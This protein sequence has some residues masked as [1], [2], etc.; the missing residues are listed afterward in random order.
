MRKQEITVGIDNKSD[1]VI[2]ADRSPIVILSCQK[3]EI[4]A[5]A[6]L[7]NTSDYHFRIDTNLKEWSLI[8]NVAEKDKIPVTV[9]VDFINGIWEYY[10]EDYVGNPIEYSLN[11]R[12]YD[13]EL[14]LNTPSAYE[15]NPKFL[16]RML[17]L[18]AKNDTIKMYFASKLTSDHQTVLI[19]YPLN[20]AECRMY[21]IFGAR[22]TE[23]VDMG[24]GLKVSH[25]IKKQNDEK[26]IRI[27]E[28][29]D[30]TCDI[31]KKIICK[32]S[33]LMD[34]E[35]EMDHAEAGVMLEKF[36]LSLPKDIAEDVCKRLEEMSTEA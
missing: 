26:E 3:V 19:E 1:L 31:Y 12:Y 16:K 29:V 9:N 24:N 23:L 25:I 34:S 6:Y 7:K 10:I 28:W 13:P 36:Y 17:N 35:N 4:N 33:I 32:Y 14:L 15:C 30:N 11:A 22:K 5:M 8:N 27:Q 21:Y 18:G 20:I 2:W